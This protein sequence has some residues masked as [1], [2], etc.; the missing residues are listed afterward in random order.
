MTNEWQVGSI[1]RVKRPSHPK[2]FGKA[3]IAMMDSSNDAVSILWEPASPQPLITTDS[4]ASANRFLVAPR[5]STKSGQK[6]SN[7]DND[8]DEDETTVPLNEL[9]PLMEFE[10][11]SPETSND[12]GVLKEHGDALLRA[13]DASAAVAYYEAALSRSCQDV[14]RSPSIGSSIIL[15]TKGGYLKVAEIDCVEKGDIAGSFSL[16]V[17][18]VESGEE[19]E[20]SNST[21]VLGILMKDGEAR[22]QERILLNLSRC[23]HQL[24]DI[25]EPK[26]RSAYLKGAI[27]ACSLAMVLAEFHGGAEDDNEAIA[28]SKGTLQSALHL[29]AKAYILLSKWPHAKQDAK[30]LIQQGKEQQGT[31]LLDNIEKRKQVQVKRD[32]KLAK[33]VAKLVQNV[34]AD[35]ERASSLDGESRSDGRSLF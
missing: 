33:A 15:K 14:M 28:K 24:A 17:A 18:F 6:S 30:R 34:T 21:V 4:S 7:N 8:D 29:R 9:L 13:G 35:G 31:S 5:I 2:A 16:D 22:L 27:L 23:L 19:M 32:K 26:H 25:D 11:S 10:T 1:A 12:I 20:V 3:M